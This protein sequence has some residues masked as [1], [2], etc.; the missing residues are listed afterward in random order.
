MSFSVVFFES[1]EEVQQ[2]PGS[3]S[4]SF[5]ST[6]WSEMVFTQRLADKKKTLFCF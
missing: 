3:A 6:S 2:A 4:G 5:I 1:P